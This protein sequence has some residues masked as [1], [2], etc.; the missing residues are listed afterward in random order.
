MLQS[1]SSLIEIKVTRRSNVNYSMIIRMCISELIKKV[2]FIRWHVQFIFA[3]V[4]SSIPFATQLNRHF[5]FMKINFS[6]HILLFLICCIENAINKKKIGAHKLVCEINSIVV[7]RHGVGI[8]KQLHIF[9]PFENKTH[10]YPMSQWFSQ[11]IDVYQRGFLI[12]YLKK[13]PRVMH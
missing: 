2:Q 5:F 4:T 11:Q 9:F 7:R 13:T 6:S 10:S 3:Q 1:T 8:V 12:I